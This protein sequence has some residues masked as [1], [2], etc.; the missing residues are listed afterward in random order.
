MPTQSK[1]L[2]CT[3]SLALGLA[4]ASATASANNTTVENALSSRDDL[5][6]FYQA[7]VNTG[8]IDELRSGAS[9]TVFAP[10][11][12]AFA[13][14]SN[15]QYPCFYSALCKTQVADILRNHIAEGEVSFS[16]PRT[17][18]TFSIDRTA[19]NLSEPRKGSYTAA[20]HDIISKNQL[21]GAVLYKIDG[22]IA[23]PQE[24]A[25]IAPVRYVPVSQL[26]P[27]GQVV[28]RTVTERVYYA[29]DNY[30]DGVSQTTIITP[31]PGAVNPYPLAPAR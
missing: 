6:M 10:T 9:Y 29:P 25:N 7:L 11:N 27:E 2:L 5:S 22:I 28:T 18:A 16:G 30:P 20:G 21:A 31:A 14:F 1:K 3:L 17:R 12:D 26:I 13:Q 8:V 19:I 23:S 4:G 24:L 15:A